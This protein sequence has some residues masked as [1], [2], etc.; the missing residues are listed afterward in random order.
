MRKSARIEDPGA[1]LLD[2]FS[3]LWDRYGRIALGV[4][5]VLVA[6]GAVG[7]LTIR[8]RAGTEERAAGRL[9]EATVLYWRGD[10]TGSLTRAREIIQQ[11]PS[12]PSGVDAH[13]LA[14]D[15]SYWS[16]DMKTAITEYRA[17]LERQK[18]GILADAV[19]RSLAYALESDGQRVEAAAAYE[20]LVGV[21]DR[22]SSAEMLAAAARCYRDA[23]QPAE[24]VK[25]LQR[26]IDE[27]GETSYAS[28]ARM[29][30]VELSGPPR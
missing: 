6:A 28:P 13:R 1:E 27:F 8:Q 3:G 22:E 16:G 29:Q 18:S 14:G 10:Y 4:L 20:G 23:G 7:F 5:G 12:T 26:L 9:A 15:N 17:Y 19:R 24:A 30:L 25:R 11:F 21:F 2:R